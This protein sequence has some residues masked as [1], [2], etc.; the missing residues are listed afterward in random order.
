MKMIMITI[1]I[2]VT[3]AIAIVI[4]IVIVKMIMVNRSTR[5]LFSVKL[6]YLQLKQIPL[7]TIKIIKV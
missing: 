4:A 1:T 2:T 6:H 7:F 3:I 5:W